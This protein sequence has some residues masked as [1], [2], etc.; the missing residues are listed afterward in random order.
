MTLTAPAKAVDAL[1]QASH[2]ESL[3]S[4][5]QS[6]RTRGDSYRKIAQ[7]LSQ[8]TGGAV[9]VTGET[10]RNWLLVFEAEVAS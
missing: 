3:E 6:R 1:L 2:G 7:E 5:L 9:D 8:L 10:I 4:F